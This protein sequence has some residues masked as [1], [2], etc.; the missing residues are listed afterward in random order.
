M[1]AREGIAFT[2]G[3]GRP[4]KSGRKDT[5]V[6]HL[7]SERPVDVLSEQEFRACFHIPDRIFIHLVDDE[8]PSS[9][10]QSHNATYFNKEQF[11][12]GLHLPLPYL[13][14]QFLHFIQ[15]SLTL[16][17]PNAIRVLMECSVM[18]KLFQLD[19]FLLEVLFVYIVN[20]SQ[21]ERFSLA[22]HIPFLQLVT[23]LPDSGKGGSKGHVLISSP[24]S[25]PF[26]G[27]NRVFTPQ[28]SLEISS[29][30]CFCNFCSFF[31]II[32]SLL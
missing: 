23:E 20:M 32:S 21:K 27:P 1:S 11:T 19:L 15:I 3:S 2:S 8:T 25:G 14:K 28:R 29:M 10:K 16:H 26:E 7:R 12:A 30:I 31:T 9:E 6:R 22:T 13:F 18:D 5:K 17:H 4:W 24:W